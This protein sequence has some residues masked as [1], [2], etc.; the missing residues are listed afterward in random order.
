MPIDQEQVN[1]ADSLINFLF[2]NP[3]AAQ[4]YSKDPEGWLK[5]NGYENVNPEAVGQCGA[6]YGA[7]GGASAAAGAPA[8]GVAGV[9]AQLNPIVYN[10]YYE[11]N[12]ITNNIA[13]EGL[14]EFDQT[15]V[16]GDGN[17]VADDGS[18]IGQAQTGDG[19]QVGGSVDDS[20]LNTGDNVQ[21]AL[22]QSTNID[23]DIDSHD[24]TG[25]GNVGGEGVESQTQ[26][27][28]PDATQ[29][30]ADDL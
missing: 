9:A 27:A 15:V 14:L 11:D 13:N 16:Q 12:S 26:V 10:H 18:V 8:V 3:G 23:T 17:I 29:V 4:D 30:D 28:S 7:A 21:Q 5:S 19:I 2:D 1:V 6:A 24:V 20:N 22:D 25:L